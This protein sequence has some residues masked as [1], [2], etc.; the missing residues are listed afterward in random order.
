MAAQFPVT[1]KDLPR[2]SAPGFN[3]GTLGRMVGSP[4]FSVIQRFL[5]RAE[6]ERTEN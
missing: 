6:W 3:T 5:G 1:Q 2:K 4:E